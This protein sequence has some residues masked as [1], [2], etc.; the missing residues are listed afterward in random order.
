MCILSVTCLKRFNSGQA[1]SAKTNEKTGLT[2]VNVKP[3]LIRNNK[4]KSKTRVTS[5]KSL[6]QIHEL[7]VQI[8][9][10]RV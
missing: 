9:E 8:H 3:P 10:L 5:Y 6:V 2:Y 1:I 7:G 4:R